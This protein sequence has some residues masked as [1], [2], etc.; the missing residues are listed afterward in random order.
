[1]AAIG[2]PIVGDGKYGGQDSFLTGGIS[3]KLHLHARR[4]KIDRPGGGSI[5]ATAE[6]P[7]HFRQSLETIGFEIAAG[8][9]MAPARA[10]RPPA[11]KP[12]PRRESRRGERRSRGSGGKPARR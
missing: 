11:R 6:L 5:D 7:D 3:R 8:D 10:T 1:M 12:K 2:H 4:L 9:R